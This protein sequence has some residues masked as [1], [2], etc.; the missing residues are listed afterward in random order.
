M[1]IGE[2][3]VPIPII[4]QA[5]IAPIPAKG[6]VLRTVVPFYATTRRTERLG[7]L[8]ASTPRIEF[9]HQGKQR[10]GEILAP[11]ENTT[12]R[13]FIQ[14]VVLIVGKPFFPALEV[15]PRVVP[16]SKYTPSR[17]VAPPSNVRNKGFKTRIPL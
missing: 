7:E 14:R 2:T 6:E 11:Q 3:T 4:R 8:T 13:A 9:T 1:K 5:T 12:E 15:A 17:A 10:F 16:A